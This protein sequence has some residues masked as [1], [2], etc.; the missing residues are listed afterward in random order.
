MDKCAKETVKEVVSDSEEETAQDSCRDYVLKLE[1]G[2]QALKLRLAQEERKKKN[3][4]FGFLRSINPMEFTRDVCLGGLNALGNDTDIKQTMINE[5]NT[6]IETMSTTD[7]TNKCN[8]ESNNT[9]SNVLHV[10]PECIEKK[11]N[12]YVTLAKLSHP[13]NPSMQVKYVQKEMNKPAKPFRMKNNIDKKTRCEIAS[14][15]K[16]VSDQATTNSLKAMVQAAQEAS[17]LGSKS[18]LNTDSCN[19]I[20][21]KLSSKSFQKAFNCC[22]NATKAKQENIASG[23][24]D[25]LDIL[26]ENNLTENDTCIFNSTGMTENRQK[27]SGKTEAK[28][29]TT[30]KAALF[31]MATVL[32]IF[33]AVAAGYVG[34]NAYIA[35]TSQ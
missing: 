15:L 31:D 3:S 16:T 25:E 11:L 13:D 22:A 24:I 19:Q 27:G 18:N 9:Q 14:V 21:T 8:N 34:V 6:E 17:G 7:V 28:L 29:E 10:D 30:Q 35:M 33:A 1:A 23:C 26:L 5:I 4:G 20:N 2:R 12:I 32:I